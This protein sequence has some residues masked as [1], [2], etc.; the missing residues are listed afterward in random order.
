MTQSYCA[1]SSA[2]SLPASLWRS[3][4]ARASADQLGPLLQQG[5]ELFRHGFFAPLDR[6][7]GQASE[8]RPGIQPPGDVSW[9]DEKSPNGRSTGLADGVATLT[10]AVGG[11]LGPLLAD[12]T[13]HG[14]LC[15]SV[16]KVYHG[17]ARARPYTFAQGGGKAEGGRR[18]GQGSSCDRD[19]A[20]AGCRVG[21]LGLHW[22]RAGGY[23][24]G[25]TGG[26]QA[27]GRS[28]PGFPRPA[29]AGRTRET[30]S[31]ARR[32][33]PAGWAHNRP[34]SRRRTTAP[35][36]ASC[37][38]SERHG[39]ASRSILSTA[40]AQV[41]DMREPWTAASRPGG[42][43]RAPRHGRTS[44]TSSA[45]APPPTPRQTGRPADGCGCPS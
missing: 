15:T 20:T 43:G 3:S 9:C 34:P 40:A 4:T 36:T 42:P 21:R 5:F 8:K 32:R 35:S 25:S 11:R 18:K 29:G 41:A 13:P 22:R 39:L 37:A 30:L 1:C 28:G 24:S 6:R 38:G 14:R 26:G 10:R 2:G 16:A 19:G 12:A 33:S 44:G 23:E 7:A 31:R 45:C 27:R 17:A